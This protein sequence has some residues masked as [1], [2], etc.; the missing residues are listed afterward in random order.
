MMTDKEALTQLFGENSG[1]TII[2]S[3]KTADGYDVYT[4]AVDRNTKPERYVLPMEGTVDE[5]AEYQMYA[6]VDSDIWGTVSL[7]DSVA[8]PSVTQADIDAAPAWVK[9]ITPVEVK[10]NEQ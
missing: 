6:I 4:V 3:L 2:H 1:W 7:S 10:D 5:D 9:A 8:A